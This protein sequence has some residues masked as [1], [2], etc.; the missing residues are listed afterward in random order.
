MNVYFSLITIF[1][2]SIIYLINNF[3]E[4]YLYI[5]NKKDIKKLINVKEKLINI[6]IIII[7]IGFILYITKQKKEK[8]NWNLI[9]FIFGTTKCDNN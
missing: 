6:E 8:Q 4:Y 3:I 9:K 7:I 2:L 1:L 5:D